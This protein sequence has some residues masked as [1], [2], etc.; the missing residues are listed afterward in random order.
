MDSAGL[1]DSAGSEVEASNRISM[2]EFL[3]AVDQ[4]SIAV[5]INQKNWGVRGGDIE[6]LAATTSSIIRDLP[7][8]RDSMKFVFNN[9]DP[10]FKET[11]H[12]NV[13]DLFKNI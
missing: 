2:I 8:I 6:K 12:S 13:I 10:E 5:V 4:I 9:F 3:M 1:E 7:E 11:F